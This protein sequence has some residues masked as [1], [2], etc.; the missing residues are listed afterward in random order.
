MTIDTD[1]LLESK[2]ENL[3]RLARSL[4]VRLPTYKRGMAYHRKL[5]RDVERGLRE[6]RRRARR[7]DA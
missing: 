2:T 7:F 4:G 6:D 1:C 3:E 5:A